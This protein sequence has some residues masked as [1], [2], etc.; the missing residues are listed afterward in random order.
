MNPLQLV[1][2]QMRQR[3]LSTWLTLLSVLLGVGLAIAI[4]IL[5]RESRSLFA[6]S[7]F[8]Y[9]IIVGP[10]KGSPLQLVLNT[11]YHLDVSP[12][13]I[14]YSLY[15]EMSRKT[16]P[17]PGGTDY[18][19]YV[20][21]AV[22]FMVGDSYLGRRIV[23]TSPEMFGYD[24]SGHP[25]QG[26]PFEYRKGRSYQLAAGRVFHP[27]KFEAVIGSDVA[28]A[29]GLTLYDDKL[30]EEENTK[31]KAT[32]QATHGFPGPNEKPDIHKPRWRVVGI[33]KPTH[34]A[35][36]RVLFI[37]VIS[38]YAI[39]EHEEGRVMQILLK[40]NLDP[41][42]TPPDRI[43]EALR[44]N[45]INV[46][47]LPPSLKRKLRLSTSPAP[48]AGPAPAPPSGDLMHDVAPKPPL[49]ATPPVK[50]QGTEDE[51][52]YAINPDGTIKPFLPKEDWAISAILVR[53]R[54]G[55]YSQK[56]LYNFK[57]INQQAS[58]ANPAT[59]M[60]DFFNIFLKPSTMMLLAISILVTVVAAVGI[61]VSIYN[62]VSARMKEIAILRALGAT[63]TRVLALICIEAG[64]VGLVGGILGFFAGHLL[65]FA[66]NLY[67]NQLLGE[68]INW[69][70]ADGS[71]WLYLLCVV[72]IAVLA[73]LVPA[74]K[75]Y[76]TPVATNLVAG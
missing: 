24:D 28:A 31:R 14:P 67:F 12:G 73:G 9:D 23:G 17:P 35:N 21:I 49:A 29:L 41:S 13:L 54:S 72:V 56:L 26:E 62:S 45:G 27:Q 60:R 33:L 38:L 71:E 16:D 53:S 30:S 48:S 76:R 19:P 3:A 70:R 40:E 50:D 36:D 32:F 46:D 10:P 68:G 20:K 7:D 2:K 37:P 51:D 8:G 65:G 43:I 52:A 22:P 18:R 44:R 11:A 57:L 6:Q 58:A 64:L 1:L 4:M 59:V 5:Q 15:E 74:L 55:F 39:A 69:L 75:A 25:V 42:A 34:T 63:R 66:G 47:E 61:L